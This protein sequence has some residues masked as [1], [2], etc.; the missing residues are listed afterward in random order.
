MR[1]TW[2]LLG[3][4]AIFWLTACQPEGRAAGAYSATLV[5]E[6]FHSYMSGDSL[7]G[8]LVVLDGQVELGEGARVDGAVFLFGGELIINGQVTG[9]VSAIGGNLVIGPGAEIGGNL[10][11]GSGKLQLSPHAQVN[12]R[13]L[14]GPASGV[15]L[16]DLFP[17]RS[18]REQL[19]RI[20]PLAFLMAVLSYLGATLVPRPLERVMRAA[21]RHPVVSAAMGLLV[22]IVAPVFLIVMAYT[23]ILIP[24]TVIGILLGILVVGFGQIALGVWAGRI[25]ERLARWRLRPPIS[26]FLGAFTFRV[27]LGLLAL[28][29]AAGSL[30]ELLVAIIVLG[31]VTLTRFGL[32]EFVP[33]SARLRE[34]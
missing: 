14:T 30:L 29:P 32:R 26:A 22:G 20:V 2:I 5:L 27:I 17:E 8:A 1:K 28:I 34:D 11:A 12:G 16:D 6:G 13:V 15:E 24:V 9:D 4:M 19:I 21:T 10:R 18:R 31:A 33:E 7:P 23:L 3:L 25:L